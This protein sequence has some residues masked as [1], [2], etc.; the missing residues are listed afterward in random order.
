MKL[1]LDTHALLW[2]V[3]GDSNLSLAARSAIEDAGNTRYIS[4]ATAWEI[5]I[6]LRLGKLQ[7]GSNYSDLFPKA[8]TA[9]GFLMLPPDFSHYLELL[10]IPLHHRDPFDRLLIAQA[11]VEKLTLVTCDPEIMAY[12]ISILW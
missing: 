11:T 8:I 4:H 9:N 6:K 2:F 7:I 3:A 10:T 12:A 1:L 5:A